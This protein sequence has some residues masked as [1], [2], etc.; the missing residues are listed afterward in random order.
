M[1]EIRGVVCAGCEQHDGRL[2]DS[3]G[4]DVLEH[5]QQFLRV[6]LHRT[7]ADAFKHP[8]ECAL[9]RA[10]IFQNVAHARRAAT[11]VFEDEIIS[12]GIAD[13]VGAADVDVN[14]LRHVE[15]R[16]LAPEMFSRK[17]VVGRN[18]TVFH[19]ALL[20]VDV[21]EK[22]IERRDA[23]FE[24]GLDVVPFFRRDD[25]RQH[26]EGKNPLRA[27]RIA[28]HVESDPL[29]HEREIHGLTAHGKFRHCERL[30]RLPHLAIVRPRVGP[31]HFIE[32]PRSCLIPLQHVFAAKWKT[33]VLA[34]AMCADFSIKR[35][36]KCARRG[37]RK[38]LAYEYRNW[39]GC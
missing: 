17:D 22:K 31:R 11:V 12:I 16:E 26:V 14:V 4:R 39:S 10:A 34:S 29:S 25:A 23:L 2:G 8:G 21:V 1:L 27:L 35:D 20:V 18:D 37:S 36:Q 33:R 28:I 3:G 32:Q 13:Q 5:L 6:V 38:S 7:D 19:D 15:A 9:H 30:E 24:A